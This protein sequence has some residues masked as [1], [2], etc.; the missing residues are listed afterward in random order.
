MYY[1]DHTVL[2]IDGNWVKAKD[3]KIDMYSQTMH[4]GIGVFEGIRAYDTPL[5]LQIF[6]ARK[7][8][9]RLHASAAAL[10]IKIPY[11]VE[12]LVELSYTL[13]QKN[14]MH[15]AYIRPLVFL[16]PNMSLSPGQ[17]VHVMITAWEWARYL[18][19][20]PLKVMISSYER[21]NPKST[22]I[23][24][25]ITGNY[26]N[27][28]LATHEAKA[29]GFD[30]GLLLDSEGFVSEGP[31]ANFFYEKDGELFTPSLGN[32]LPG[33]TRA[34]VMEYAKELGTPIHEKQITPEELSEADA[35]F[36][37]GTAAEIAPIKSIENFEYNKMKWEDTMA[38]SLSL[39][40]KHRVTYS[41]N[42]DF[43]II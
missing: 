7:H 16:G 8:F 3:A 21:P 15:N 1:N 34:T 29:K 43:L 36:F 14:N 22:P 10:H 23:A 12:E 27:S 20:E 19:N 41:E 32:I 6:K 31:G 11:S 37:T 40:Y 4:Y 13:L 42:T 26:T 2:F 30:E 28:I 24:A 5:G 17:E 9:E 25:K 18:G 39:M 33:I 35:A 38:Y